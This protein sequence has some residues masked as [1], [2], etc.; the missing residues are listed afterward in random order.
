MFEKRLV[1]PGLCLFMA[2]WAGLSPRW[3]FAPFR[4]VGIAG[5][6]LTGLWCGW[7]RAWHGAFTQV[8]RGGARVNQ[9]TSSGDSCRGTGG[10]RINQWSSCALLYF[11]PYHWRLVALKSFDL[12][13]TWW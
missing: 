9:L 2:S 3:E 12:S 5:R 4:Y 1:A 8:I 13:V 6:L 11:Y 7:T 10:Q